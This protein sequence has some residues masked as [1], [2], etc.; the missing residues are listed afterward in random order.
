MLQNVLTMEKYSPA[1]TSLLYALGKFEN[2]KARKGRIR[3]SLLSLLQNDPKKEK[4]EA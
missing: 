2:L 3:M 4:Y 1:Y